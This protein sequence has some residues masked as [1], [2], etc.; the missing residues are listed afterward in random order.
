MSSP[1][2][3][4]P[5]EDTPET[6]SEK[7]Q[8]R[9][10]WR[11]NLVTLMVALFLLVWVREL[12]KMDYQPTWL[13]AFTLLGLWAITPL[14]FVPTFLSTIPNSREPSA[15]SKID[16]LTERT[17]RLMRVFQGVSLVLLA[18]S[19]AHFLYLVWQLIDAFAFWGRRLTSLPEASL[20][21]IAPL[22]E[23]VGAATLFSLSEIVLRLDRGRL[24]SRAETTDDQQL[25]S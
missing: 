17:N 10:W 12:S 19:C 16:L 5:A 21:L 20:W 4:Q 25:E 9:P 18:L 3:D 2:D 13:I 7:R 24:D 8:R 6:T 23:F 22:M 14:A 11:W 1:F 15:M